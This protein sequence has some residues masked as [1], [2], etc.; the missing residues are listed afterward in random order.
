[1]HLASFFERLIKR[2]EEECPHVEGRYNLLLSGNDARNYCRFY[3]RDKRQDIYYGVAVRPE[4]AETELFIAIP[5]E[6]GERFAN[7]LSELAAPLRVGLKV[8]KEQARG[9][10]WRIG[11]RVDSCRK[12]ELG[13]DY[14]MWFVLTVQMLDSHFGPMLDG[15][16]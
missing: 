14:L 13:D 4:Y 9:M 7:T 2:V 1:M 5:G 11:I 6:R 12:S 3:R 16:E 8:E 10:G 15:L